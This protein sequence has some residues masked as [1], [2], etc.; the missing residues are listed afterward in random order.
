MSHKAKEP[1]AEFGPIAEARYR[2]TYGDYLESL[3]RGSSNSLREYC[4]EV[5]TN[6]SGMYA[7]LRSQG[8]PV[9]SPSCDR[10]SVRALLMA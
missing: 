5:R 6:R 10:P 8:L 7:W 1:S 2:R 9:P 3:G 4:S